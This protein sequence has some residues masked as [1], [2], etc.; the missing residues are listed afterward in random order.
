MVLPHI[1]SG[2]DT[3]T[4]QLL[5]TLVADHYAVGIDLAVGNDPLGRSSLQL[6]TG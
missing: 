4:P 6:E 3:P 5:G 1:P 2:G